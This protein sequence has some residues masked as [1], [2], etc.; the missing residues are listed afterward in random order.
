[1]KN[2]HHDS[3]GAKLLVMQVQVFCTD[4]IYSQLTDE[5]SESCCLL[6]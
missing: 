4:V 5:D 3:L 1:M 6:P 2:Q